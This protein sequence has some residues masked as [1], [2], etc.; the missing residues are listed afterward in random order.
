MV[1]AAAFVAAPAA[2][3][4]ETEP[5]EALADVVVT[6]QRREESVQRVPLA[7]TAISGERIEDD[8]VA[9]LDRI[10]AAIPNLYLARNFGTSSGALVFLRGVGEGDSIFTNDPP[11]GIYV[12]DVIVPRSTGALFDFLDVER[13]EV[14]R[15]PQ[16][17]LYGRNTSGGAIKLVTRRPQYDRVGGMADVALGSYRRVDARVTLN[18]PLA[19]DM[20]V[21]ASAI[22]R[23]QRGWGRNLTNGRYVNGQDV[24]GGR[25]SLLWEPDAAL[26]LLATA[27][28]THDGSGPRFPQRFQ[29]DPSRPGRYTNDFVAPGSDI[30][31]FVSADTDPLNLTVTG[32]ASLRAEYRSGGVTVTSITGYRALHSRIGFDQTANPPGI[33]SNIILLQDQHQHSFSQEFQLT[34]AALGGRLAWLAGVYYFNEHNDQLTAVSQAM[35]IGTADASFRNDDFFNALSRSLGTGGNWSPY[36]P[37]L[38]TDSYSAFGSATLSLSERAHVTAGLRYTDERKRYDVRFLAAPDTTLVLPDGRV[39]RRRIAE[40]WT[41][42]SPRLA[43]DYRLQDK[44]GE[45]LL[46]ASAAKGFRSGSFDGRA[47]N[48]GF[49]LDRQGA[50]APETVWNYEV[51]VKSDWLGRRLRVNIDYFINDYTDIAFSASR[52]SAGAPEIFRQNVGDARIQGVELEWEARPAPWLDVGGWVATLADRFTR[53]SSSP[54]CTAFV[55]DER[56]LDL[57]FTPSF[58]YQVRAGVTQRVGQARVRLGGNVSGA[59]PYNIALCNEPQH[60]VSDATM[61]NLQASM[62]LDDWRVTLAAT[63]VTD[64][65]YNTG[66]VGTIG[67]PVAP[68]EVLIRIGLDF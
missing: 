66:S 9:N 35:P 32:G 5:R 45:A 59:S 34:G 10:G 36:E 18:L 24:Q 13:V 11:V 64:W 60:R 51:G 41:D 53:L 61:V 15:G 12:D 16:G 48:I 8:A 17:T 68:R 3:Q 30:D 55:A 57:R 7:V 2:A 44:S 67:Y 65:R 63:N 21:R 19:R 1:I 56:D 6:A 26:S 62:A 31:N 22:S 27:D 54:G 50:I 46:Y 58:R 52:A 14:L 49:A 38:D 29:P 4:Q 47:R 25:A 20:A 40:R 33:G 39:A 23:N 37:R 28:L 42:L 43:L